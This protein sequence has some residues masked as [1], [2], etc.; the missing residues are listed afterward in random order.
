MIPEVFLIPTQHW[1]NYF[2]TLP[3]IQGWAL[4]YYLQSISN[5]GSKFPKLGTKSKSQ[6]E[7]SS[8]EKE[9]EGRK[10]VL[11]PE[12][13]SQMSFTPSFGF[14]LPATLTSLLL[15]F[16]LKSS[17]VRINSCQSCKLLI[18]SFITES[19]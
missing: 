2:S 8:Q 13:G 15:I 14:A 16:F 10:L 18:P 3:I 4:Y 11:L 7:N 19:N 6:D 17:L 12:I 1:S 9:E 5:W